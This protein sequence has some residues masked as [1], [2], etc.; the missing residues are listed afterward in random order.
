MTLFKKIY[1]YSTVIV[2]LGILFF[3]IFAVLQAKND[4]NKATF[5]EAMQDIS[6]FETIL[7]SGNMPD[8]SAQAVFANDKFHS[9]TISDFLNNQI[10]QVTNTSSISPSPVAFLFGVN[11][12]EIKEYTKDSQGENL[13]VV[14]TI[15]DN[16]INSLI[17][18]YFNMA[19]I[20]FVLFFVI[21]E[22][23]LFVAIKNM[24]KP[25]EAIR[26]QIFHLKESKFVE[27]HDYPKTSDLRELTTMLNEAI[28]HLRSKFKK[29]TEVLNKYYEVIYNDEE[30]GLSNR[31]AF[32]MHLHTEVD[33]I[34]DGKEGVVVFI[35]I[36]NFD[37][38]NKTHGYMQIN[39]ALNN[40]V[41][42]LQKF[43]QPFVILARIK[44]DTFAYVITE[45]FKD[46]EKVLATH[47]DKI[48]ESINKGLL[49]AKAEIAIS[50]GEFKKGD[51]VKNLLSRMDTALN[52]ATMISKNKKIAHAK[53]GQR[54]LSKE[55]RVNLIEY[56][57]QND[58]F[59]VELR[60][61]QDLKE[62]KKNF[63]KL[64]VLLKDEKGNVYN[65]DEF[66]SILHE[67]GKMAD[68]DENIINKITNR[69]RLINQPITVMVSISNEFINSLEHIRWLGDKL[70]EVSSNQNLKI[71]FSVSDYL[72]QHELAKVS[73]FAKLVY[74]FKHSI[75]ISR[76]KL[77]KEKQAYL[78]RLR[79]TY[80]IVE[81]D[82]VEDLYYE[83]KS[84]V[85]AIRFMATEVK[86]NLIVA[87]L[88]DPQLISKMVEL[89]A[90]YLLGVNYKGEY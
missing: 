19:F 61:L 67:K 86:S 27:N 3:F 80:I 17:Q 68:F 60:P 40:F 56:A 33:G 59:S 42:G 20:Y 45:P 31:T 72:A 71:C 23:L 37:L 18:S 28:N 22:V 49:G 26:N 44:P 83:D 52:E 75:A 82:Y 64:I 36:V 77:D 10:H 47:Y 58:A 78:E 79:P 85:K 55:E 84:K 54:A 90:D 48:L 50:S 32:T 29:D 34:E 63:L 43:E 21:I 15:N 46:K 39:S 11:N 25:I 6:Q 8:V 81:Q 53:I 24:L 76:F 70:E 7:Q 35:K 4:I 57:F 41:A 89:D 5:H 87:Y 12:A 69:Y 88:N 38:L 1:L 62:D 16:Y 14:A 13:N 51:S 73:Q 9:V 74:R 30:T 2:F 65:K 66:L